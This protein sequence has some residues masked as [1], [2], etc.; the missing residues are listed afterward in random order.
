MLVHGLFTWCLDDCL[1][2]CRYLS[3]RMGFASS[4]ACKMDALSVGL[5]SCP[6]AAHRE[7]CLISIQLLGC[8]YHANFAL[9][10]VQ[11]Q[12]SGGR[13]ASSDQSNAHAPYLTH[14]LCG[15]EG[16]QLYTSPM[17]TPPRG[18][19]MYTYRGRVCPNLGPVSSS[20]VS[21]RVITG[22]TGRS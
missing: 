4:T 12:N 6:K 14:Q 10:T 22:S 8:N 1:G 16:Q 15:F 9:G 11:V 5:R 18:K 7:V 20:L 17:P 3:V 21:L 13:D 2:L 19:W